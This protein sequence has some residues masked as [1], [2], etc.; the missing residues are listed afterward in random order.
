[1]YLMCKFSQSTNPSLSA[2]TLT[3]RAVWGTRRECSI[4]LTVKSLYKET[5]RGWLFCPGQSNPTGSAE[6]TGPYSE[7]RL[8]RQC[9]PGRPGTRSARAGAGGPISSPTHKRSLIKTQTTYLGLQP[10]ACC[11]WPKPPLTS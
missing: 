6:G 3:K 10:N 11:I 8:E 4:P 1:M 5:A 7:C 2:A 9:A